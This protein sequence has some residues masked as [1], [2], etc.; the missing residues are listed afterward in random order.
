MKKQKRSRKAVHSPIRIECASVAPV[1]RYKFP[2]CQCA[3]EITTKAPTSQGRI[4]FYLIL[5]K[6]YDGAG[7]RRR[8]LGR[9]DSNN[10]LH[11]FR[12]GRHF[13][14]ARE[15]GVYAIDQ[16]L[17]R[18]AADTKLFSRIHVET[19]VRGGILAPSVSELLTRKCFRYAGLDAQIGFKISE[20]KPDQKAVV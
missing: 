13:L 6:S 4:E 7:E 19:P 8:F 2:A 20:I 18:M 3:I 10:T 1:I 5:P 15:G 9:I 14:R 16:H 12:D 11:I 17:L